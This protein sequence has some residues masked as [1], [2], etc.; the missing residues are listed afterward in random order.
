MFYWVFIEELNSLLGTS[1][2]IEYPSFTRVV[3]CTCFLYLHKVKSILCNTRLYLNISLLYGVALCLGR[4]YTTK[5][6]KKVY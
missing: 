4:Y 1:L 5:R 6:G 2:M 3:N